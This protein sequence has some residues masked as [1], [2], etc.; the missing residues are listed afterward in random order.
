MFTG[1]LE[2]LD[3]KTWLHEKRKDNVLCNNIFNILNNGR[4][5]M[6]KNKKIDID[7]N[8][9][10][11]DRLSEINVLEGRIRILKTAITEEIEEKVIDGIHFGMKPGDNSLYITDNCRDSN[12]YRISLE[13]I[14]ELAD[15]LNHC[16]SVLCSS[17]GENK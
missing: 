1:L 6:K 8:H 5:T 4:E 2:H 7:K 11:L 3:R 15:Y 12:L 10:K 9:T 13:R 17:H 16:K 14:P